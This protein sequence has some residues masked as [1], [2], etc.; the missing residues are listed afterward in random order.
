M[1]LARSFSRREGLLAAGAVGLS[2]SVPAQGAGRR[3]TMGIAN[4]SVPSRRSVGTLEFLDLVRDFGMGGAQVPITT[5]DSA[6]A[7][8]VRQRLEKS[9]LFFILNTSFND[10]ELFR[11]NVALAKEAGAVAIRVASGGRRYED[12]ATLA[13]RQA[14][15]AR[16]LGRIRDAIPVAE[17]ARIPIAL[18]NHKDFTV[19]EHVKLYR[20]YSS[21]YFGACVDTGNNL[22]L[23][24]DPID[25]VEKLSPYAVTAHLK[26]ATLEEYEEGFLLGDIPLGEGF[27]DL[28]QVVSLLRKHKPNLP[29]LLECITR[30]PLRIPC[31]TDKYW[32]TFPDRNGL[33]LAR[34][35]RRV[36]AHKPKWQISLPANPP[37]ALMREMESKHIEAS[38]MY[39][40]DVLRL[41]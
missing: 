11:R 37:A 34:A 22:A 39:A 33:L 21:E 40:R 31:L 10:L 14:H 24:E 2:R 41:V 12:F 25:V 4:D 28:K 6:F 19:D 36:R 32:A 5:L 18:E 29:L 13:E 17:A 26:D 38:I 1:G 30:N 8:Q 20:D 16:V 35:L 23:L 27:L 7:K 15:V 3:T 9:G